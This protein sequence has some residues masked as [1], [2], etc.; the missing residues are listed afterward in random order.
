MDKIETALVEKG[1]NMD[2]WNSNIKK[3]GRE[4]KNSEGRDVKSKKK[5]TKTIMIKRTSKQRK[6]PKRSCP[7]KSS[8]ELR[9][10]TLTS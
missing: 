1:L 9:N 7:A 10:H 4:R 3:E 2:M 8:C 5:I 6:Y